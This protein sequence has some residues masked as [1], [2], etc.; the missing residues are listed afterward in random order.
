MVYHYIP[1]LSSVVFLLFQKALFPLSLFMSRIKTISIAALILLRWKE[2]LIY[3]FCECITIYCTLHMAICAHTQPQPHSHSY[4]ISNEASVWNIHIH[5][6]YGTSNLSKTELLDWCNALTVSQYAFHD[7]NAEKRKH[8]SSTKWHKSQPNSNVRIP[9]FRQHQK[10]RRERITKKHWFV[11]LWIAR[12][13]LH[14]KCDVV[15]LL[16]EY[17]HSRM[18]LKWWAEKQKKEWKKWK[19]LWI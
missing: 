3:C 18:Y 16:Y 17:T 7:I 15:N 10:K 6:S 9:R 14:L 5:S 12:N 11:A 8:D 13:V 2:S 19:K 1:F 4:W